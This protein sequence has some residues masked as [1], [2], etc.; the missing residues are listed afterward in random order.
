[1]SIT[2][3]NRMTEQSL[4]PSGHTVSSL[5]GSRLPPLSRDRLSLLFLV[6][7]LALNV[8]LFGFLWLRFNQMPVLVPMHF[9]TLGQADR[10]APRNEIFKLP[11][12]GLIIAGTNLILGLLLRRTLP[13]ATYLLWGGA[14][15]IEL[16]LFVAALN[17][18]L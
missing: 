17:I 9:D 3:S 5:R 8:G 4:V 6:L 11:I 10:I 2:E 14:V 15:L 7:V 18:A 16:L 12:I 13:F 1:M